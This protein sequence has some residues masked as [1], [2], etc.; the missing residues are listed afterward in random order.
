[1]GFSEKTVM[2]AQSL[3]SLRKRLFNSV[4]Y[5][6]PRSALCSTGEDVCIGC[7]IENAQAGK[8][9]LDQSAWHYTE[10]GMNKKSYTKFR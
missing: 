2:S 8:N 10:K 1:V 4:R 7:W 3:P 5:L 9:V 6:A